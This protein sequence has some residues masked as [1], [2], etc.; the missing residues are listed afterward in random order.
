MALKVRTAA[1]IATEAEPQCNCALTDANEAQ[2][3]DY[4]MQATQQTFHAIAP[5]ANPEMDFGLAITVLTNFQ[6]ALPEL[7]VVSDEMRENLLDCVEGLLPVLRDPDFRCSFEG[8]QEELRP[9]MKLFRLLRF[10]G[11]QLPAIRMQQ[12]FSTML[13]SPAPPSPT[14]N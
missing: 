2:K 14:S 5:L 4:L 10:I 3:L 9:A 13:A 7:A 11:E 1:E 8:M 6:A 12:A